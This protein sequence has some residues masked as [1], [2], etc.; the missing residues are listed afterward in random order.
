MMG[1]QQ[2]QQPSIYNS[3]GWG[4]DNNNNGGGAGAGSGGLMHEEWMNVTLP[5]YPITKK[6]I[7]G[8]SYVMRNLQPDHQYEARVKAK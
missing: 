6:P 7:Q 5:A 2:Q 1:G 4:G 8:M 3:I